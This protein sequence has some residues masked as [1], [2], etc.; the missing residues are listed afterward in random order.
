MKTTPCQGCG[1]EIVF[2]NIITAE[3]KPGKAPLDPRPP[4][5]RIRQ[6]DRGEVFGEREKDCL[7]S[8]F[9]TCPNAARFSGS[10]KRGR[11]GAPR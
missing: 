11:A 1:R 3:G 2:A 10:L 4:V 9:A 7:V 6:D 5:Y 8:H